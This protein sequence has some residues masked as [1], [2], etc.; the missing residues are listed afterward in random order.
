LLDQLSAIVTGL[1][2]VMSAVTGGA[3]MKDIKP[4]RANIEAR[5]RW[6][7]PHDLWH[8]HSLEQLWQQ[9]ISPVN[10]RNGRPGIG[11]ATGMRDQKPSRAV[12]GRSRSSAV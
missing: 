8:E 4:G 10:T 1:H 2:R 12:G 6:L 7:S 5:E 3:R 9:T 11:D